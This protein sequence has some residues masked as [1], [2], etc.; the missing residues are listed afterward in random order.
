MESS[1]KE[2]SRTS[3][4]NNDAFNQLASKESDKVHIWAQATKELESL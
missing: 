4:I 1:N 2:K 3:Q